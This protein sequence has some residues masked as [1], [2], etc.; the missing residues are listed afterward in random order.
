MSISIPHELKDA[1]KNNKLV[2]FTGA[3]ASI[4]EGLPSWKEIVLMILEEKKEAINKSSA[5][6]SALSDDILTPIEV[7]DKIYDSKKYIFEIFEKVLKIKTKQSDFVVK[8]SN[9]TS[10]FIT[11]NFDTLIEC[12]VPVLRKITKDSNYNLTKIDSD[13]SYVLKLHGDIDTIDNCIIFSKQYDILYSYGNLAAF[14]LKKIFSQNTVLFIGFSFLDQYVVKLFDSISHLLD[15]LGPTHYII[16]KSSI[17]NKNIKEITINDYSDIDIIIDNLVDYASTIKGNN[18]KNIE[19]WQDDKIFNIDGSDMP[20]TTINWVGRQKEVETLNHNFK[21]FFITGLGGQGKSALAAHYLEQM[22]GSNNYELIGWRDFK[23]EDHK[24]NAK[25]ISLI[26]LINNKLGSQHEYTGLDNDTLIDIFFNFLGKRNGLFVFDNV[27]SY[28]DLE[29]LVPLNGI[30]RLYQQ[31]I[32]R[33]HNSKFIFTCRPFVKL[34]GLD[35]FQLPLGGLSAECVISYFEKSSL[36]FNHQK[37]SSYATQTFELTGGHPLWISLIVAQAKR[38]ENELRLFLDSISKDDIHDNSITS[39]ISENI[40]WKIWSSLSENHQI[41]FRSLAESVQS[42]TKDDYSEIVSREMNYNKFNKALKAVK[43]LG[44][45]VEK[46]GGD[47]IELH[48]LVKEFIRNKYPKNERNR[49]I[50]MFIEYYGKVV[51]ILK[52]KLSNR[53]S[54]GDFLNWTNRIELFCNSNQH[55]KAIDAMLEIHDSIKSAGYTEE[56]LRVSDIF[57]K[58][59]PWNKAKI[60]NLRHFDKAYLNTTKTAI[61]YGTIK[62]ADYLINKYQSIIGATE[63]SFIVIGEAKLYQAWFNNNYELANDIYEN[64]AFLLESTNKTTDNY[65]KYEYALA[66][67]DSKIPGNMEKA[68]G[69]F[70]KGNDI[71]TISNDSDINNSFSGQLYGNI[72]RCLYFMNDNHAS[73]NCICKSFILIYDGDSSDRLINLG[74]ASYWISEILYDNAKIETSYYFYKHALDKWEK[75]S[76][77]L[78]NKNKI[79]S[80]YD[81]YFPMVQNISQIV[82]WRVEQFCNRWVHEKIKSE[83]LVPKSK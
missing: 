49:F 26:L 52:P 38:G 27:D 25:I 51:L 21:V 39:I 45:I 29:E 36:P 3:G 46:A 11:T 54:L 22:K 66:L 72:G 32:T 12:S 68:L 41:L 6:A 74:Y 16:T 80:K 8:L 23:E 55:Q 53:L 62:L 57:Y 75:S 42:L 7:L 60:L 48:P 59:I 13:E 65:L 18:T 50:S 44:L 40:L 56:Y 1:I 20:P 19:H 70:L 14:Q 30:E 47:Y 79:N 37:I 71:K 33:N 64:L 4:K 61:E 67:R 9:I 5:Y 2:I 73:L 34:A 43:N 83:S 31:A 24:F 17:N 81:K 76:P 82:D 63:P 28:I 78:F 15:D 10:K 35:F 58:N 69:Y 77:P